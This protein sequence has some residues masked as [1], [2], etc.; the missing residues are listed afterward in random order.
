MHNFDGQPHRAWALNNDIFQGV[1]RGYVF[2]FFRIVARGKTCRAWLFQ[3][4]DIGTAGNMS[5]MVFDPKVV[6]SV[7][8]L[9]QDTLVSFSVPQI[10]MKIHSPLD[11]Y[12]NM[13][14]A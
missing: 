14:F 7:M 6:T 3:E 13:L 11:A 1:V 2:L 12:Y 4:T 9:G 5:M 10:A 8:C